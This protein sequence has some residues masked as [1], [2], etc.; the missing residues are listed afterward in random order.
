MNRVF[1]LLVCVAI[2]VS[3]EAV[4]TDYAFFDI[5]IDGD[6]AGR[7]KFGL[8]GD[9]APKTVENFK[10]LCTGEYGIGRK[11]KPLHYKDSI[12]HRIIP[13]F[14]AQGG[15]FTTGTGTGGESIYGSR[16]DDESFE[17]KHDRKGILSMANAGKNTNGS[18]F[19]ITTVATPWLNGHH[20][21][22]GIVVDGMDVLDLIESCG[23][24]SGDPSC[25]VRIVDSGVLN[26]EESS[27][28]EDEEDED[29]DGYRLQ[30]KN[31][32]FLRN[33]DD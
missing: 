30:T 32:G 27:N 17:I 7:I 5:S 2:C 9:V 28:E 33:S 31:R 1:L 4:I 25:V 19:F 8:F 23:T 10:G 3:S 29:E 24:S 12:F 13:H 18:Q 11:G 20:V 21:A 14:M 15:D 16:F 6:F 26:D 22:F